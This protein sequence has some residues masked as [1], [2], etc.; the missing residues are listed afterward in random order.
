MGE[1]P[2]ACQPLDV[3]EA[4]A[5][6]VVSAGSRPS[7]TQRFTV[8]TPTPSARAT[9]AVLKECKRDMVFQV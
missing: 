1:L 5:P 8:E 9:T 7:S 4:D 3:V 2:L 6:V